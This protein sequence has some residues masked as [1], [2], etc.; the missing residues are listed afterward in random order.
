MLD[1]YVQRHVGRT[2]RYLYARTVGITTHAVSVCSVPRFCEE[3]A[4]AGEIYIAA[5]TYIR[6]RSYRLT[7]K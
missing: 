7:S 1:Q 2:L 3:S 5:R 6:V 4:F